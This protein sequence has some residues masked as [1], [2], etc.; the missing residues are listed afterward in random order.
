MADISIRQGHALSAR[1]ARAA[2]E[3]VA[4]EMATEF[5]M[6]ITWE[7][8]VL[9]FTRSGVSGQLTLREREAQ[10]DVTLGFMLKAF[11]QQIEEKLSANMAKV[12][13]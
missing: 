13:C 8:E 9:N 2:A 12:F 10:L 6:A 4:A 3:K 7:G 11:A 5:D 1:R